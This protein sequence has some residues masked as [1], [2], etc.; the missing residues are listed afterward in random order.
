MAHITRWW[1]AGT[2]AALL[3]LNTSQAQPVS[4]DMVVRVYNIAR[5]PGQEVL[6]ARRV[7]EKIFRRTGIQLRWRDCLTPGNDTVIA[8]GSCMERLEPRELIARIAAGGEN[9]STRVFG[10][11]IVIRGTHTST[12]ATVFADRISVPVDAEQGQPRAHAPA[13]LAARQ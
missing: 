5:L 12:M 10:Q 4:S 1:I 6:A 8:D 7:A 2:S 11:A 3:S 9:L 13:Q